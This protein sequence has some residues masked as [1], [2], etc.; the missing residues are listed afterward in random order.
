MITHKKYSSVSTVNNML[1]A[2]VGNLIIKLSI[3]TI[4]SMM[5]TALYNMADTFFCF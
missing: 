2:P 3:P 5:I 4:V 1:T